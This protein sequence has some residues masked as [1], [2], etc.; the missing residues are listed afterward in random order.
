MN[1]PSVAA[2]FALVLSVTTITLAPGAAAA[3]QAPRAP[4]S[5]KPAAINVAANRAGQRS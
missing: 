2:L 5:S 1:K 4:L 3:S